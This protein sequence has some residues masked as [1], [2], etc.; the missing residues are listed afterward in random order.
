M[1]PVGLA[2]HH[3]DAG[4]SPQFATKGCPTKTGKPGTLSQMEE[5]IDQGPPVSALQTAEMKI[6][7]EEVV[8]K[9]KKGKFKVV[10]WDNIRDK[11]PEELKMSP[12]AMIPHKS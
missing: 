12:T 9:D 1:C 11:E 4:K 10:L 8:A 2:L 3:P 7:V 5:A 6:L